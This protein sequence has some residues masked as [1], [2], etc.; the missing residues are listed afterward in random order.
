M[1]DKRVIY[2]LQFSGIQIHINRHR[3]SRRNVAIDGYIPAERGEV[4]I[5][6]S[7][8]TGIQ[9]QQ[10]TSLQGNVALIFS[11]RA[12]CLKRRTRN[13]QIALFL[14]VFHINITCNRRI[15]RKIHLVC[16][17]LH[18]D[19]ALE[20][21]TCIGSAYGKSVK[22]I[23][24]PLQIHRS[25]AGRVDCSSHDP[26]ISSL[27]YVAFDGLQH[28]IFLDFIHLAYG[29]DALQRQ[30]ICRLKFCIATGV[31]Q[32]IRTTAAHG[33]RTIADSG[34]SSQRPDIAQIQGTI[35]DSQI[36]ASQATDK[37]IFGLEVH[38]STVIQYADRLLCRTYLPLGCIGPKFQFLAGIDV[39]LGNIRIGIAHLEA[40]F[41]PK[42]NGISSV[43]STQAQIVILI[44]VLDEHILVGSCLC[45]IP[46]KGNG[47]GLVRRANALL[48]T[49]EDQIPAFDIGIIY[50]LGVVDSLFRVQTYVARRTVLGGINRAH[51]DGR[52]FPV[53]IFAACHEDIA[54]CTY[55]QSTTGLDAQRHIALDLKGRQIAI[56]IP[57]D[58]DVGS[59]H[60]HELLHIGNVVVACQLVK[61]NGLGL[62]GI[63]THSTL[64]GN[65]SDI[66][67]QNIGCPLR[68]GAAATFRVHQ[69]FA[70]GI[71][72]HVLGPFK[73]GIGRLVRQGFIGGVIRQI[74]VRVGVLGILV[75]SGIL[76]KRVRIF[77]LCVGDIVLV[78][79]IR[80]FCR[81][82]LVAKSRVY[83]RTRFVG[84]VI[85]GGVNILYHRLL[86]LILRFP[87]GLR[88][89]RIGRFYVCL[90][91][92]ANFLQ[93]FYISP[94][95]RVVAICIFFAVN[96]ARINPAMHHAVHTL[97]GFRGC[98]RGQGIDES[99]V[100][101]GQLHIP[102]TRFDLA[103]A[104]IAARR[105]FRQIDAALCTGIDLCTGSIHS[106]DQI[107]RCNTNGLVLR[108]DCTIAAAQLNPTAFDADATA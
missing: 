16:C 2:A 40:F 59:T 56:G 71:K 63:S 91:L 35:L 57:L 88:R 79:F 33:Q 46:S 52:L 8:Q 12:L 80:Q 51:V 102:F 68:L 58:L 90:V 38:R 77:V 27:R 107:R 17:V 73:G 94:L 96:Q 86:R 64:A 32:S 87:L 4:H 21:C 76:H 74:R 15:H 66:P 14:P 99:A 78:T 101:Y 18:Q 44:H 53:C 13:L 105:C 62:I 95:V 9:L 60:V 89:A 97:R 61:C 5:I 47:Q 69:L 54:A 103:H 1:D 85:G 50:S 22:L 108:A 106:I 25:L 6:G 104:H 41:T 37:G 20:R 45:Q 48:A 55:F 72:H 39:R 65:Q 36:Q 98:I 49:G 19:I 67:A 26:S 75:R 42:G 43:H 11:Q 28:Q 100:F 93:T 81:L 34:K 82:C 10:A 92:I 23:A 30:I 7:C 29:H 31:Y 84:L 70:D 3:G 24:R 83:A